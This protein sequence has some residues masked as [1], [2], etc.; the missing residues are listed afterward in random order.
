MLGR[1][2]EATMPAP[3]SNYA[4]GHFAAERVFARFSHSK[5]RSSLIVRPNAVFGMPDM[6]S[7]SRWQLIP[8]S[9]P[10]ALVESGEIVLKTPGLQRRN[11][12]GTPTIG[13]MIANFVAASEAPT[14]SLLNPVGQTTQSIIEF[15]HQVVGIGERVL[16][17]PLKV[18]ALPPSDGIPFVS[19]ESDWPTAQPE[20]L[21]LESYVE[22]ML[23]SLQ[24]SPSHEGQA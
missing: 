9:F 18:T 15:A 11:F 5:K 2:S 1:V 14:F 17:R 16:G 10:R 23:L 8:Y 21:S 19:Y 6:R 7:F 12:I 24:N 22:Q 13:E 3:L 20:P 4:I